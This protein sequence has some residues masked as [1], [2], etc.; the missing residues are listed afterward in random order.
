MPMRGH[1]YNVVRPT[2]PDLV[3]NA[4][5]LRDNEVILTAALQL[6]KP[7]YISDE[8]AQESTKT[9]VSLERQDRLAAQGKEDD[10]G[11][12]VSSPGLLDELI[13]FGRNLDTR[14]VVCYP[15]LNTS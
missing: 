11:L 4:I 13:S 5:S 9:Y 6:G 15:T 7:K 14:S 3:S 10:G 1:G 2:V 8:E 12:M